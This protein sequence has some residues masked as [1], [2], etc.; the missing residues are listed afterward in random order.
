MPKIF[1]RPFSFQE[2]SALQVMQRLKLLSQFS[3]CPTLGQ[4]KP[5]Y[6]MY[7]SICGSH[8][9]RHDRGEHGGKAINTTQSSARGHRATQ[10]RAR[11]LLAGND[12]YIT[13]TQRER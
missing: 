12:Y 2:I 8:H 7:V 10:V 1:D 5:V 4:Q 11:A 9:D 3:S 6:V 13:S